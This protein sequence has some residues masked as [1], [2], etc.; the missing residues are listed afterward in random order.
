MAARVRR[1]VVPVAGLG[2]RLLPT[3]RVVAKEL[4]PVFDRPALD[5]VVAEAAEAG[6]EEL[7]LVTNRAKSAILRHL[8]RP[9]LRVVPVLQDRPRGLG[10][11]VFCAAPYVSDAPFAVL[12]PDHLA[13][14]SPLPRLIAAAGN[15]AA[16]AL[17]EVDDPRRYG[18]ADG[19]EVDGNLRIRSLVEKPATSTSRLGIFGR[20]VLPPEILPILAA[21]PP[22]T[23]GEIQL[24][25]AL[26]ALLPNGVTGVRVEGPTFDTG[27]TVGLL[28][29]SLAFALRSPRGAEVRARLGLP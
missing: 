27:D 15:G 25:D 24:T 16:V 19:E 23:G 29:A 5:W 7:I 2:T 26:V 18:I 20:Y 17:V 21:L 1:A 14:I 11:A 3:T 4:L 22:G 10:H 6:I 8:D 12:L 28:Q 9:G 13:T